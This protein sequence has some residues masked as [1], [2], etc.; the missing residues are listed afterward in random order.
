MSDLVLLVITLLVLVLSIIPVS[1]YRL[2][3]NE[4]YDQ[5]KLEKL[6]VLYTLGFIFLVAFGNVMVHANQIYK[7][8]VIECYKLGGC[9]NTTTEQKIINNWKVSVYRDSLENEQK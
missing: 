3:M 1:V 4:N 7:T 2:Y 6:K 9:G 5:Y 8:T